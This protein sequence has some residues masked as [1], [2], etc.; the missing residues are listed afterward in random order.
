MNEI[1]IRDLK[2]IITAPEGINLVVIRLDTSEPGLTG[3]GCATL[4]YRPLA[5]QLVSRD[6][7]KT[8]AHRP[9]RPGHRGSL[10]ADVSE[11]VLAQ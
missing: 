10:A 8:S 4:A 5:V 6:L 3:Y 2:C 11:C 9:K 7:F 1:T